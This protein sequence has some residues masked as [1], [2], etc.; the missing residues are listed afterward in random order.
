MN[1]LIYQSSTNN[2][3]LGYQAGANNTHGGENVAIGYNALYT[4]NY[5]SSPWSSYNVAVGNYALYTTN[6]TS[7][8]TT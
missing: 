6:A 3:F 5:G 2:N 4:L 8:T 7:S 1:I